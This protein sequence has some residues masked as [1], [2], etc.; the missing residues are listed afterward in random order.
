M[1]SQPPMDSQ[2]VADQIDYLEITKPR[3]KKI[4]YDPLPDDS[5]QSNQ[6]NHSNRSAKAADATSVQEVPGERAGELQ[7]R[8]GSRNS[9]QSVSHG[10]NR[11]GDGQRPSAFPAIGQQRSVSKQGHTER[12]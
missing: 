6:S 7:I 4:A 12:D 11:S 2:F 8:A 10:S 3:K 9:K 5:M 1:D